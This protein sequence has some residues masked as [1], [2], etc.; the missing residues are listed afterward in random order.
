MN[1]GLN[2][3]PNNGNRDYPGIG[4]LLPTVET[5]TGTAAIPAA[6]GTAILTHEL[7]ATPQ[8]VRVVLQ[9]TDAGGDAGWAQNDEIEIWNVRS[10]YSNGTDVREP[11]AFSVSVGSSSIKVVHNDLGGGLTLNGATGGWTQAWTAAKWQI[12]A[13]AVN[14]AAPETAS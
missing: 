12:K 3:D 8:M 2:G 13:Y 14:L 10:Q 4:H 5:Y 7:T 9:C 1:N 6:G 11:I